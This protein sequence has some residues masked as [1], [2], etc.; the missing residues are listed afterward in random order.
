MRDLND[1]PVTGSAPLFN[2]PQRGQPFTRLPKFGL[3][4]CLVVMMPHFFPAP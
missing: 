2:S 1:Q 4:V 3:C